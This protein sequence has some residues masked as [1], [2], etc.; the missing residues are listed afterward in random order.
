MISRN[1]A[2]RSNIEVF[3][4][5]AAEYSREDQINH[6]CLWV[7]DPNGVRIVLFEYTAESAQL[8]GGDRAADW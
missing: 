2:G 6:L 8:V 4:E 3:L 7:T 1:L 5:P